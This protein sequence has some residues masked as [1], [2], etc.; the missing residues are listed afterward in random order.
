MFLLISLVKCWFNVM[1]WGKFSMTQSSSFSLSLSLPFWCWFE[2]GS[3]LGL[4]FPWAPLAGG[5][6]LVMMSMMSSLNDL[7]RLASPLYLTL[8]MTFHRRRQ[9]L[10]QNASLATLKTCFTGESD[11]D[12]I[13]WEQARLTVY[14][15][16]HIHVQQR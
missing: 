3:T 5:R 11:N 14:S 16:C 2:V 1:F 12:L 8:S 9:P 6:R 10:L 7:A 15:R 4:T 13:T